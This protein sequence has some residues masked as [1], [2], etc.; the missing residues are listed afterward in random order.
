MPSS[1]SPAD[2]HCP[3]HLG[4][5]LLHPV[6]CCIAVYQI[7]PR[8]VLQTLKN[9]KAASPQRKRTATPD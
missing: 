8:R 9:K 2:C 7:M 6:P 5:K 1:L 3:C 4:V